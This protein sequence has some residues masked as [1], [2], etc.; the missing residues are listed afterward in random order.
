MNV[1][2]KK[3]VYSVF[4][5]VKIVINML[6]LKQI[7]SIDAVQLKFCSDYILQSLTWIQV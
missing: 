2:E 3:F 6:K 4:C 5:Y 1:W 7:I